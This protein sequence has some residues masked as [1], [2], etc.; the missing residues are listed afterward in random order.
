MERILRNWRDQK[1][2]RRPRIFISYRH[3]DYPL[4]RLIKECLENHLG[5]NRVFIDKT[6][7]RGGAHI[8]AL[9]AK[10]IIQSS[11]FLPITTENYWGRHRKK[12]ERKFEIEDPTDFVRKELL[13]ATSPDTALLVLKNEK[14]E[15]H[16]TKKELRKLQ[17]EKILS[18]DIWPVKLGKSKDKDGDK[19]DSFDY[20][21]LNY[22]TQELTKSIAPLR[23]TD[24]WPDR[25]IVIAKDELKNLGDL[26]F[27]QYKEQGGFGK[28]YGFIFRI[29]MWMRRFFLGIRKRD[30]VILPA[31]CLFAGVMLFKYLELSKQ[32]TSIKTVASSV[33]KKF[34][35]QRDTFADF[36]NELERIKMEG[37]EFNPE[38]RITENIS[39]LN[40]VL[41]G[42][43]VT[44]ESKETRLKSLLQEHE[45]WANISASR[46]RIS[47]GVRYAK[48]LSEQYFYCTSN[49]ASCDADLTD[50]P[51][52]Y[53]KTLRDLDAEIA[54]ENFQEDFLA[55][56]VAPLYLRNDFVRLKGNQLYAADMFQVVLGNGLEVDSKFSADCNAGYLYFLMK[57]N[58]TIHSREHQPDEVKVFSE[59]TPE[60]I[61]ERF[62][63]HATPSKIVSRAKNTIER[64]WALGEYRRS[65]ELFEDVYK[66][67]KSKNQTEPGVSRAL[68]DLFYGHDSWEKPPKMIDRL[69]Q[70]EIEVLFR[71]H[72]DDPTD[73][74]Q[75]TISQYLQFMEKLH[76]EI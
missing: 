34:G 24:V 65:V 74:Y 21:E 54:R 60:K 7:I 64:Y 47:A 53:S 36:A 75:G 41:L 37:Y 19:T 23:F 33:G 35:S 8:E 22:D 27:D 52:L 40:Q 51:E 39:N 63:E 43:N 29:E 31:I 13:W 14:D 46:E 61:I 5:A 15:K 1:R 11:V 68:E 62:N 25:E 56:E 55:C 58:N 20:S 26:F 28:L 16:I 49:S 6:G 72:M 12:E 44:A 42:E 71:E 4:A 66:N 59:R 32:H 2:V 48:L 50:K 17:K 10:E 69:K 30:F 3:A 67:L 45:D 76:G 9:L 38:K 73:D 18:L 57:N 70:M